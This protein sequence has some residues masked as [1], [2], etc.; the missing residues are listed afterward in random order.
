LPDVVDELALAAEL[1]SALLDGEGP[2]G[3]VLGWV[4]GDEAQDRELLVE[5][6]A[7]PLIAH[8]FIEAVEWSRTFA[9]GLSRP[10]HRRA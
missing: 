8:A 10:R 9:G 6:G 3:Q 1:R 7:S 2:V 5:V 4:L